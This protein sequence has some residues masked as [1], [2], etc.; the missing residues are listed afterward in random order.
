M[1]RNYL[2][3]QMEPGV[4]KAPPSEVRRTAGDEVWLGLWCKTDVCRAL[5]TTPM[6]EHHAAPDQPKNPSCLTGCHGCQSVRHDDMGISTCLTRPLV[7]TLAY[8]CTVYL[9]TVHGPG[10]AA[11]GPIALAGT[12]FSP[13]DPP[14]PRCWP[15]P[16]LARLLA[17]TKTQPCKHQTADR[18]GR[19]VNCAGE[20]GLR[21][22]PILL[23]SLGPRQ[24]GQGRES[25]GS[26]S[27]TVNFF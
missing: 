1:P 14:T 25:W 10:T 8:V 17:T 20:P 3:A 22:R 27:S 18:C 21:V 26:T 5:P 11:A 9:Y 24:P 23:N 12:I 13:D 7:S 16:G 6:P 15:S 19:R 2:I 4:Y